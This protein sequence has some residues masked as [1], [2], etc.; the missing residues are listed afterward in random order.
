MLES[1]KK[2]TKKKV[3]KVSRLVRAG[4]HSL[5]AS[6]KVEESGKEQLK[7]KIKPLDVASLFLHQKLII[8]I[9]GLLSHCFSGELSSDL[10]LNVFLF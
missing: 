6:L 5:L 7:S 3:D 2:S 10:P 1:L 9:A 8:L 4:H